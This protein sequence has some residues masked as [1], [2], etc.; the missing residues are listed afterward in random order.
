M[1]QWIHNFLEV[2]YHLMQIRVTQK[3]TRS[4]M[5]NHLK[6]QNLPI[7]LVWQDRGLETVAI[8]MNFK[9]LK[10]TLVLVKMILKIY[11]KV[12]FLTKVKQLGPKKTL[13]LILVKIYNY[14]RNYIQKW[15]YKVRFANMSSRKYNKY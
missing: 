13:P 5:V 3:N 9:I 11:L 7:N 6:R 15:L 4:L 2:V 1:S 14:F 8:A 12:S 10:I